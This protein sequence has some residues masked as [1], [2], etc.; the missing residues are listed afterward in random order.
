MH[1]SDALELINR[2]VAHWNS[3]PHHAP[4]RVVAVQPGEEIHIPYGTFRSDLAGLA[5]AHVQVHV[6]ALNKLAPVASLPGT[7]LHE[8]GHV[9]YNTSARSGWDKVASEAFAIRF[10]IDAL[11]R[12]GLEHLA[13]REAQAILSLKD[14]DPYR[15]A[16]AQLAGDPTWR[17]Y[18]G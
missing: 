12:E 15:S 3:N 11:A 8:L 6:I 9:A 1:I 16:I 13:F 17:K 7:F 18:A 10:S 2:Y 14:R 5:L 4:L